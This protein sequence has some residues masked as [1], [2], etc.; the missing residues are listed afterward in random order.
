MDNNETWIIVPLSTVGIIGLAAFIMGMG[1]IQAIRDWF[2]E[3]LYLILIISIL[4]AIV[5]AIIH[6]YRINLSSALCSLFSASQLIFFLSYGGTNLPYGSGLKVIGSLI[7]FLLYL[8]I[9]VVDICAYFY[10]AYSSIEECNKKDDTF[11]VIFN[12]AIGVIGWI[13]NLI[14]F[15]IL[16]AVF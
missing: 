9:V 3:N 7:V 16:P 4:I 1:M 2:T 15:I 8:I 6:L 12:L 13:V 11:S 10:I 5:V 14:A